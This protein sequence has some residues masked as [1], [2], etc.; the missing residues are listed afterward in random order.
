M[1]SLARDRLNNA[2]L[3]SIFK[4]QRDNSNTSDQGLNLY[5]MHGSFNQRV[6][7]TV[8]LNETDL[9]SPGLKFRAHLCDSSESEK[10]FC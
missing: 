8:S 9:C 5:S 3:E 2:A 7:G 1:K 4:S 6:D 10:A